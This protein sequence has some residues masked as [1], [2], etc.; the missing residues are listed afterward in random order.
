M[1]A[2]I[3]ALASE[4]LDLRT[5]FGNF[6][7][8]WDTRLRECGPKPLWQVDLPDAVPPLA[9]HDA[10]QI[11]HIVQEALTKVLKHAR[12]GTVTV[13]LHHADGT[14]ALDVLDDGRAP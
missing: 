12:A 8:R 10:L 7:F 14:L 2:A 13:R 9:P 4:E 5:S 3:E 6:R 11:L 1:R